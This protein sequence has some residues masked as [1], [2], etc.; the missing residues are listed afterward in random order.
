MRIIAGKYRH[1]E[2]VYPNDAEH[3][4][5]TK[6]R[7]REALFSALGPLDDLN[8]LDLYG[9]SG[10]MAI[11]ALS[12]HAK[13]ATI[14]DNHPIAIKTIKANIESLKID[15]AKVL[16]M[17]DV[18]ALSLL[19]KENVKFDLIILDPPYKTGDYLGI[20]RL[21]LEYQLINNDGRIVTE[22]DHELDFSFIPTKKIKTYRYGEIIVNVLELSL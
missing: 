16:F 19:K 8:V 7:I 11:E 5:P 4:R 14:V 18:D 10:A 22:C 17:K 13:E 21:L 3:I 15:N 20:I 12:R 6:D 2:I 9:G 1:R